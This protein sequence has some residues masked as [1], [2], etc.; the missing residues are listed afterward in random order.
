M[1]IV[2]QL[3]I[4]SIIAGSIYALIA[5]GFNLIYSVTKF[6][7]ITHGVVAVIGAYAVYFFYTASG[8]NLYLSILAA[9][10]LAGIAGMLS[11]R[12]IF[13]RL[14]KKN[15][16]VITMFVAS[17][18]LFTVL[19][20]VVAMLFSNQFRIL[21]ETFASRKTYNIFGAV[22]TEVHIIIMITVIL[23]LTGYYLV[24]NRTRFGKAVKAIGDDE[25]V[26]KVI[27]IDTDRIITY[28]FFIGSV[29]AGIGGILI[30]FDIGIMPTMGM[31]LLLKAATASIIGGVG[32]IYGGVLGALLIGFAENFSVWTISGEWK[33]AIS[34]A[35]LIIFLLFRPQGILEK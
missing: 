21:T 15:A 33:D 30:G 1:E 17:L 7:N 18:G 29:I 32:N 10:A 19:Q 5:L 27:G 6:F 11:D 12:L 3:I 26:A 24:I 22:L 13:S 20:A 31:M 2:V 34:F 25:E 14:R 28:V 9:V 4:N 35:L 16:S 23:L 8:Y